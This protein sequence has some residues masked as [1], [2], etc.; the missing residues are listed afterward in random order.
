MIIWTINYSNSRT[1][2]FIRGFWLYVYVVDQNVIS[3]HLSEQIHLKLV[4]WNWYAGVNIYLF[5]CAHLPA[6]GGTQ[7]T[8][9]WYVSTQICT[10]WIP[11][12]CSCSYPDSTYALVGSCQFM[13]F[14]LQGHRKHGCH[15]CLG[16][17]T[18]C[19]WAI[20][21]RKVLFLLF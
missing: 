2:C 1:D 13:C 9:A 18:R 21:A 12:F 7:G 19:I 16:T 4:R 5:F 6:A 20:M 14:Q 15:R 10:T 17:H 3:I 11:E 8:K